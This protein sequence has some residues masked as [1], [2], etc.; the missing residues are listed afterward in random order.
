M[1]SYLVE[2][3]RMARNIAPLIPEIETLNKN[4]IIS[5]LF[6]KQEAGIMFLSVFFY[7]HWSFFLSSL[8]LLGKLTA[9]GIF[10]ELLIQALVI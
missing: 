10:R 5:C 6:H 1:S 9:P 4:H 2:Q 3:I 7:I 8:C